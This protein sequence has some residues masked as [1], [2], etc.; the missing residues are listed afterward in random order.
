MTNFKSVMLEPLDVTHS[1][2]LASLQHRDEVFCPWSQMAD[3]LVM[4]YVS[5]R[6]ERTRLAGPSA[7]RPWIWQS[8]LVMQLCPRKYF[9]SSKVAKVIRVLLHAVQMRRAAA[10]CSL[11]RGP[12]PSCLG[13]SAWGCENLTTCHWQPQASCIHQYSHCCWD[14]F[15]S[16]FLFFMDVSLT[17]W[18]VQTVRLWEQEYG[19]PGW[20]CTTVLKHRHAPQA[21]EVVTPN[22]I[23]TSSQA[24]AL[25]WRDSKL[26]RRFRAPGHPSDLRHLG[27]KDGLVIGAATQSGGHSG[28]HTCSICR[29]R[30]VQAMSH[31]G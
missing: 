7:R 2:R 22:L 15:K 24:D 5:A 25:L 10:P 30:L 20:A 23:L 13:M 28:L 31:G 9:R 3:T 18:L 16:S 11:Q 21:V 29:S 1:I 8:T 19:R 12:A 6:M 26:V 17:C 4:Q 14:A 27:C